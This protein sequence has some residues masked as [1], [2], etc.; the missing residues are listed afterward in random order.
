M[1][2]LSIIGNNLW[3]L[4]EYIERIIG[5]IENMKIQ[6]HS[7]MHKRLIVYSNIVTQKEGNANATTIDNKNIL[8]TNFHGIPKKNVT[9]FQ[10]WVQ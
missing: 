5:S 6:K 8:T 3:E 4:G 9:I 1:K 7:Q 10:H 2:S